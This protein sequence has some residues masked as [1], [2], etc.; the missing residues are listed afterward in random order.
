MD[1]SNKMTE[2]DIKEKV[3]QLTLHLE[4]C[5]ESQRADIIKKYFGDFC[6]VAYMHGPNFKKNIYCD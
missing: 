5:D 6:H 3:K 1:Q 4:F 2:A